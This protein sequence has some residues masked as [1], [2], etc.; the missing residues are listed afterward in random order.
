MLHTLIIIITVVW[1]TGQ[2]FPDYT[3]IVLH[4]LIL[5]KCCRLLRDGSVLTPMVIQS[6]LIPFH[7]D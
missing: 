7:F 2:P 4:L 3:A 6:A 5:R 1:A